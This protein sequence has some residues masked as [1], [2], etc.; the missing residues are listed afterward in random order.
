MLEL[1]DFKKVLV[2]YLYEPDKVDAVVV[3]NEDG[4][5][6]AELRI[7]KGKKRGVIV[8]L[9]D[10]VFGWS[11]C[12]TKPQQLTFPT[13]VDNNGNPLTI[14][15]AGDVFDK[16]VGLDK[17][18]KRAVI[19]SN[20]TVQERASFYSKIPATLWDLLAQMD[21]RAKHYFIHKQ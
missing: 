4:S 14:K 3:K 16:K 9:D 11:L 13:V 6:K 2:S 20:L 21:K 17:A 18:L 5:P 7:R 1:K 8:A 15:I 19:A 10:G 12:N